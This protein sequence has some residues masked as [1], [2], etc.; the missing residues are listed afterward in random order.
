M[1]ITHST[2]RNFRRF[3]EASFPFADRTLILG[4]NGAGKTTI[5]EACAVSLGGKSFRTGDLRECICNGKE[6]FFLKAVADTGALGDT[7]LKHGF[8]KRGER[9]IT[10]DGT[11]IARK[12]LLAATSFVLCTHD[13]IEM[14]SGSPKK[15]R[16]FL[17]RVVMGSDRSYIETVSRYLRYLKQKTAL[18]KSG[19]KGGLSHLNEAAVPLIVAIRKERQAAAARLSK[20]FATVTAKAGVPLSVEIESFFEEEEE[21]GR[22]LRDR[23]ERELERRVPLY[24]PHLDDVRISL[25]GRAA[26]S[27]SS[28]EIAFGAFCLHLAETLVLAEAGWPPLF[29]GDEIFSFMDDTRRRQAYALLAGLP[30]QTIITTQRPRDEDVPF[31]EHE[32]IELPGPS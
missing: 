15:R 4:P 30:F 21:T 22:R 3:E 24:G 19:R 5:I 26:K 1:R 13:D 8:G 2:L 23:M 29:M 11:T 9:K 27:S 28:G 12:T 31:G 25:T 18:L 32:R 6:Y 7:V 10:R 17:D 20:H 16:D 14:M